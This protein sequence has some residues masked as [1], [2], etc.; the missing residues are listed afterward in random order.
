VSRTRTVHATPE[1]AWSVLADFDRIVEWAPSVDHSEAMTEPPF[2]VGA[3]RRVQVGRLTLVE[4]VTDWEEPSTLAYTL[5]GLPPFAAR[6]TN[7]WTLEP[8]GPDR[9]TVTV[10]ADVTPG[11]RPPMRVA[12]AIGSRVLARG[13]DRLL[14]GLADHLERTA[15]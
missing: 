3:A 11:P 6:A 7:R 10:T 15:P 8:A 14:A 1:Q 9:T 12:A 2:G 4:T 13:N 5:E